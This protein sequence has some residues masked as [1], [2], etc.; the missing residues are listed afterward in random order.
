MLLSSQSICISRKRVFILHSKI[1]TNRAFYISYTYEFLDGIKYPHR[2]FGRLI[3]TIS[4]YFLIKNRR[5]I[6]APPV[7]I[8]SLN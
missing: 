4:V 1:I 5:S 3:T 6:K 2:I 8:L 7:L